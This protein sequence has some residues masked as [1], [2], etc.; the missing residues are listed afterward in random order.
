[1]RSERNRAHF[2]GHE[3]R[4]NVLA[5]VQSSAPKRIARE[6]LLN[7]AIAANE[8]PARGNQN[9]YLER[10]EME[11]GLKALLRR[12]PTEW[13]GSTVT[14]KH[15]LDGTLKEAMLFG[16]IID[17]LEGKA[18]KAAGAPEDRVRVTLLDARSDY[19]GLF[20]AIIPLEKNGDPNKAET[21]WI[22]RK[23]SGKKGQL[24]GPFP[25]P[26]AG[27]PKGENPIVALEMYHDKNRASFIYQTGT[28]RGNWIHTVDK[29]QIDPQTRTVTIPWRVYAAN[30]D[31]LSGSASYSS[32][33][34]HLDS[35]HWHVR[36]IDA[37]T[38]RVLKKTHVDI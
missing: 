4:P 38:G 21:Y 15:Q 29:L 22:E 30:T 11:A 26:K 6:E 3:Y 23:L 33:D 10:S 16:L 13:L 2:K 34:F 27:V 9:K 12:R 20:S 32:R 36:M 14:T 5:E 31:S 8:D 1:M 18:P 19:R 28:L 37:I 24:Y 7:A 17:I 35:G 25:M